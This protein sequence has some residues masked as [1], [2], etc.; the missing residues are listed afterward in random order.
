MDPI[1]QGS[2]Y[3]TC[4]NTDGQSYVTAGSP[5]GVCS[6]ASAVESH[7]TTQCSF[8]KGKL[9][10]GQVWRDIRYGCEYQLNFWNMDARWGS[11]YSTLTETRTSPTS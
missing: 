9:S 8:L 5:I 1:L 11:S 3:F 10:V 6:S 2:M 7:L 4:F